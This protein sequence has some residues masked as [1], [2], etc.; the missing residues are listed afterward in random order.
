MPNWTIRRAEK[1]DAAALAD[2]FDAAYSIY[3]PRITDLPA[4]SDGIEDDIERNVVWVVARD[5]Q[6]IG[7][8]VLLPKEDHV[9][10]A[11]V[12]IDPS[13][14][15]AGLGRAFMDLA[16]AE[17]RKLGHEKLRL[18]THVDMPE[19]VQLY[20]HLGWHEIGRSGNKV[21][22]EKSLKQSSGIGSST[23]RR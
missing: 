4:V 6:V 20:E 9:V 5:N 11:N 2:C 7:G 12:A 18:S 15:G 13:A 17:A 23:N 19:N 16:E 3:A 10:L 14:T 1:K 8:L 22:M 21:H